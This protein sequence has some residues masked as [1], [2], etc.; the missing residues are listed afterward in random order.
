MLEPLTAAQLAARVPLEALPASTD[1]VAPLE[2]VTGQERA[3]EAIAFGVGLDTEGF[4]IAV[5]GPSASGR[6][7]AVRLIVTAAAALRTAGPDWCYLHN[8]SDPHRPVAAK[9]PARMGPALQRDMGRLVEACR[10]EI[11]RAFDDESYQE[12]VEKLLE[13]V[14]EARAKALEE[15]QRAAAAQGFAVNVT[16]MGIAAV[17]IG[18]DGRPFQPEVIAGLP[19]ELRAEIEKRGERVEE[20]IAETLRG[21][22][23]L[24]TQA[25]E[26]VEKLDG[27]VTRFVVGHILDDLRE[28]YAAHGLGAH[29]DAI[30]ADILANIQQFK[31][32]TRMMLE[33][34]PAQLV[35][36][37]TEEREALLSQYAVNVFVTDGDPGAPV[38]EERSPTYANLFGRIDYQAR[39]GSLVTDFTQVRAGAL[40]RANN[41][42][43]IL[44]VEELLT[45]PR[46]W[47]MLKRSLKTR[48]VRVEGALDMII[49]ATNLVPA[50]IP[51][52]VKIILIGQPLIVA[53]LD[54]LDPDFAELFKIRAEFEP[55]TDL[56]PATASSYAAYVRRVTDT[57]SLL[58]FD[59]DALA[60]L[61]HEGTRMAGR[62]DRLTTRY[63]AI[64][65]LCQEANSFAAK[66]QAKAV[67]APHVQAAVDA[68]RRRSSLIPDRLR[69]MVT[70]GTVR[71]ETSGTAIGQVNGLAVYEVGGHA[72]GT[73]VRISCRT[74]AGRRGVVAIEREVERSGAIHSKG[75]LVLS[76]YLTGTFGSLRA[77][78]FTA[79]LTFEQS[80]D[81]VEGDSAS[82]AELYAILTALA[83]IPIRQ[84][85]AVTG[86]VD[87]F[88]HIQAVGGV[89]Q[90]I[91]GFFDV[92][93]AGGLSGSQGVVIPRTNV[94]NLTLR[95]DVV[96][97]V[98]RGDFHIW[99]V[100]AIE[101]GLEILTG[102][103]GGALGGDGRYTEGSVLAGVAAALD[104]MHEL[105][106][107]EQRQQVLVP[108]Q[109]IAAAGEPLA[110]GLNQPPEGS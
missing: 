9:L 60:A 24:D 27:E 29:I 42:F 2:V 98:E 55:D 63:G 25:R 21:L 20:A 102:L 105:A 41:G 107:A 30:E 97:A 28:Q 110:P 48:E 78:A 103:P 100:S 57:C 108:G 6:T 15:M 36:Q 5:S 77:L 19:D 104:R 47:L 87:Q 81:E 83:G 74:G 99:A 67:S 56:T 93:A 39:F 12:R 35:A 94:V 76:G 80:Y 32:F 52:S 31:R 65:D 40:H 17:P 11:P 8:F 73:P 23:K 37:A 49:P 13:P 82:S 33:P 85:I 88:G 18:K 89:T 72:F 66:E 71:V 43:L 1:D 16:P 90:K 106:M 51:L 14:G 46:A 62:Q 91:E 44:Q 10:T 69:R 101:E 59:R 3:Q 70:E 22:R 95:P 96:A 84:D 7:T 68:R 45:D 34:L 86:S 26:V 54:A 4:N 75:I 64:A 92:C 58:P 53:L 50:A 109:G 38:V 79:S 61:V